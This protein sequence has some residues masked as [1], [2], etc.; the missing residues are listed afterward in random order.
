MGHG[1]TGK[2]EIYTECLALLHPL[3]TFRHDPASHRVHLDLLASSEEEIM[4]LA[5]RLGKGCA[6]DLLSEECYL[7]DDV[8]SHTFE[9]ICRSPHFEKTW[10]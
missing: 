9:S 10:S 4:W 6:V 1:W 5:S 8:S 2:W 7:D 3:F